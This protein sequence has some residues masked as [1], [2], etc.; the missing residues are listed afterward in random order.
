MYIMFSHFIPLALSFSFRNRFII[1]DFKYYRKCFFIFT[2]SHVFKRKFAF[3]TIKA[4]KQK[5]IREILR[6][7]SLIWFSKIRVFF[8]IFQIIEWKKGNINFSP[9]C[10]KTS[11]FLFWINPNTKPYEEEI[12]QNCLKL[13]T[14]KIFVSVYINDFVLLTI[15]HNLF[16][17]VVNQYNFV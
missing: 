6:E 3:R 8:Y 16:L 14:L 1:V 11:T 10:L 15:H 5:V 9:L 13:E 4:D 2:F 12:Y 7:V 17:E